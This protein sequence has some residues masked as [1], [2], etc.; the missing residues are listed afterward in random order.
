MRRRP[1]HRELS[2]ER[3]IFM[4]FFKINA[5]DVRYRLGKKPIIQY[6]A[7]LLCHGMRQ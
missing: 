3:L 2:P 4:R 5:A 7:Q 1:A 6:Y